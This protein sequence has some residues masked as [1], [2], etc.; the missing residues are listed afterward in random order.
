MQSFIPVDFNPFGETKEIEK[1]TAVNE[2]QREIWLAC[3]IGGNDANL[4]Y[5]ES[6]SLVLNGHLDFEAFQKSVYDLVLRHEALRSTISPNGESLII[7]KNYPVELQLEDISSI[8]NQDEYLKK[9]VRT[10]M[11]VPLDLYEGPL[12][13]VFIQKLTDTKHYFTLIIHHIIGDGWS[14]GIIIEDLAKLYNLYREGKHNNLAKPAQI[15]DYAIAQQEFQ[16]SQEFKETEDFWLNLYQDH[17]PLVDLPVDFARKS[18]RTHK[19]NRIDYPIEGEFA[20]R[21]K[22]TGA[23]VG[24]SLVTTLLTAFELFIYFKTNSKDIVIG[25]PASGQ[26]SSELCDL[27]GHCVNLLPIKSKIDP[28]KS[29]IDYLKQRKSEVLDAYDFQRLTFGELIKKLYIP[30]DPSRITLVPVIFNIDM[31]MDQAVY[32]EGLDY[33]L[34]SNPRAYENFEVYLNITGSKEHFVLEWSYN[35]DLFKEETINAFN[36]VYLDILEEIVSNPNVIISDL[37][38]KFLPNGVSKAYADKTPNMS[39][40]DGN[41]NHFSLKDYD[42]VQLINQAA[43]DYPNKTAISYNKTHL[44]YKSL[45]EKSNQLANFLKQEGIGVGAIVGVLIDRSVEMLISIVAIIKSGAAYLPLDPEYPLERIDFMLQDSAAKMLLVSR[46]HHGKLKAHTKE[47]AIENIFDN[48]GQYSTSLSNDKFDEQS[49]AYIL[50]TSGTTGKPKGTKI[51]RLNMLNFLLSMKN[52]PGISESDKVLAITTICFDISGL[53]LLLPLISGAEVVIADNEAVKDGRILL[54]IMQQEGITLMQATPSTWQMILDSGWEKA[55][56]I[57]VLCGGEALTKQLSI[58]LLKNCAQLWN[59]YGPTETTV[60]STLKQ[61]TAEDEIITIGTPINNT[62]VYILDQHKNIVGTNEAGEI[63][64]GGLGVAQGYLNR[65]ELTTEKFISDPFSTQANAKMYGTGDLGKLMPSGEFICLGRIDHQVKIRGYRI[66]LG[67]IEARLTEQEGVRQAVV[68]VQ[69]DKN[70]DKKLIAYLTVDAAKASKKETVS[71]LERWNILYD[72][73]ISAIPKD[74]I[75]PEGSITKSILKQISNSDEYDTHT[76]EWLSESINRIKEIGAKRIVEIGCGDGQ[77]ISELSPQTELYIA[78]DYSPVA[79]DYINKKIEANP[80]KWKNVSALVAEANDFSQVNKVSPDLVLINS[81][82]Q[83]FSSSDYLFDVIAKAANTIESGCIFI[84]DVQG[85]HSLRMHHAADQFLHS[86]DHLSIADFEERIN[87]RIEIEDELMVD[88]DFFYQLQKELPKIN[89]VEIQLRKGRHLNETTKYHYDVWLYVNSNIEVIEPEKTIDWNSLYDF[90][91]LE[92]KLSTLPLKA[93]LLKNIPNLR[94][95]SDFELIEQLKSLSET[96]TVGILRN[97]LNHI[98]NEGLEPDIFWALG[99][100]LGFQTHVRWSNDGTDGNFEAVFIPNTNKK[101]GTPIPSELSIAEDKLQINEDSINIIGTSDTSEIIKNWK[102][103]LISTLPEYMVPS[104]LVI[105]NKIPL[106]KT[107][108]VNRKELPYINFESVDHNTVFSE[109]VT[110]SEKLILKIW[111]DILNLG[112]ISTKSDFFELGGHSLLAVKVM[113]AIEKETQRRLPLATLF[114]N[115][116]IEKLARMIDI[117]EK[118]IKWDSLV[119]I[120]KTGNKIPIYLIHGGG[121][122]VLVFS[123]LG[124]YMHSEQ[125]VYGMQALGLDGKTEFRYSIEELAE[126]YNAEIINNDPI[127][128]YA[129]A[130]YSYGGL[131]AY[132]MAKKLREMGKE[133]KMLGI[134]DTN[135]AGRDFEQTKLQKIAKKIF[136]QFRKLSFFGKSFLVNPRE[137][138]VYQKKSITYKL[139]VLFGAKSETKKEEVNFKEEIVKSYETAYQNYAMKPFDIKVDLFR[140]KKRIYFLDDPIYLGWKDYALDGVNIHEVPGDHKTFLFPPNDKEFAEILQRTLDSKS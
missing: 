134:L 113:I 86:S 16:L 44:S 45:N 8:E 114:E 15:S 73:G 5:N 9:F 32:F 26:Q 132:E 18:P 33:K 71:W 37:K 29:F 13:K 137:V 62:Q 41:Q 10:E 90:S 12:F 2:S 3:V 40:N 88:P 111:K 39:H 47:L 28:Q 60:W 21:I 36:N 27:V 1:I 17:T 108:K 125:P 74:E 94:L 110:P 115:S 92:Q 89:H 117:D 54:D 131:I 64:I 91:E 116:T 81:V 139:K 136:R 130:G 56:P 106:S 119:A 93:I 25:L 48:L 78:T 61:I 128:P 96:D 58:K 34:I 59:M 129:I 67:E 55:M 22:N 11:E 49:L 82:V 95:R 19:G 80:N 24:S 46:K 77:L 118:E 100:K 53:E 57:K 97:K 51:T 84:G 23:K 7:Y 68:N 72:A 35:T 104:E 124:K 75:A 126:R 121:L 109:A 50:Y 52:K 102:S 20:N 127:G 133:V 101:I 38:S 103:N 6:I 105:L 43:V 85:K 70:G 135:A 14:I 42:L 87:R 65:D 99:E 120:K 4:S 140:V 30:R 98:E 69:E 83:Y 31:G 112:S 123:S 107:G 76:E 138:Y 66:E 79:I 63:Y 122:N